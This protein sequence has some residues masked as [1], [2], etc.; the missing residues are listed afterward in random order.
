LEVRTPECLSCGECIAVCP[1]PQTLEF[2]ARR[3]V[4]SPLVLGAATLVIFFGMVLATQAAGV[5][6]PRPHTLFEMTGQGVSLDAA[7]IRGSMSLNDIE[8]TYGVPA[9]EL[10]RRLGLPENTDP[11]RSVSDIM[12]ALDR[13]V[14]EVRDAVAAFIQ[15]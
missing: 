6:K 2:K 9:E 7:N 8:G 10:I 5:W 11:T 1:V 3:R 14:P 13:G 15:Q 4:V 12:K